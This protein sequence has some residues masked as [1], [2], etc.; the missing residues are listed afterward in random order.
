MVNSDTPFLGVITITDG[1]EISRYHQCR[2]DLAQRQDAVSL[3]R[4]QADQGK[5]VPVPF[6]VTGVSLSPTMEAPAFFVK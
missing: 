2:F 4:P 5:S 3:I 1:K 6:C